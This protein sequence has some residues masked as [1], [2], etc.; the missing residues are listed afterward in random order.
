MSAL[1]THHEPLRFVR[2]PHPRPRQ[3][4]RLPQRRPRRRLGA[5]E[6]ADVRLIASRHHLLDTARG[7]PP[8]AT[9]D[10]R[11]MDAW[12]I[13]ISRAS[14]VRS[15]RICGSSRLPLTLERLHV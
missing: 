9:W 10:I 8:R 4:V 13:S 5:R 6:S 11:R 1:A 7:R 15:V 3:C 12:A 2:A 14:R